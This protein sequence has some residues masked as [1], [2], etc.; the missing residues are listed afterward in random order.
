[1]GAMFVE[2]RRDLVNP[3]W[4]A[5]GDSGNHVHGSNVIELVSDQETYSYRNKSRSAGHDDGSL[6]EDFLTTTTNGFL[7]KRG[8]AAHDLGHEFYS[9]RRRT[10]LSHPRKSV[11]WSTTPGQPNS[12]T[13]PL[14]P[15]RPGLTMD[16]PVVNRLTSNEIIHFGGKLIGDAIPNKPRVDLANFIGELSRDG[17]PDLSVV[18]RSI[19]SKVV[20]NSFGVGLVDKRKLIDPSVAGHEFLNYQ[21]GWLP[22]VRDVKSILNAVIRTRKLVD[23]YVR[24]GQDGLYVR[25]RRSLEPLATETVTDQ[26]DGQLLGVYAREPRLYVS[27]NPVGHLSQV[28]TVTTRY[29]L[30]ATFAYHINV[31]QTLIGRLD[32]Y[33]NEAQYLLGIGITPETLW[34]LLP[35]S[36][37]ID[38]QFDIGQCLS[39]ASAFQDDNLV[40]RWCY[41]MR[42]TDAVR[43]FT[44][45]ELHFKSG[46]PG[47]VAIS[48]S[49]TLKERV[50]GTPYGFSSDPSSWN[51]DKWAILA[52][53]GLTRGWRSAF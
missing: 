18:S 29:W 28:D 41:L 35:F 10:S 30:S 19:R 27:G 3:D 50:H 23:D 40:M 44:L 14:V 13:G 25:R 39:N 1:M 46:G 2:K 36:W 5:V 21:F 49:N 17:M 9:Y 52:A 31:D 22:L 42:R 53:L 7:N 8:N 32:R 33:A 20:R 45:S 43:R 37:L 48:F 12:Y 38:W 6:V 26:G 51:A 47:A 16:F 11:A 34:N 4:S 24:N 15:S